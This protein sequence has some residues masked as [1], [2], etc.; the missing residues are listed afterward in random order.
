HLTGAAGGQPLRPRV[1]LDAGP[2]PTVRC[3]VAGAERVARHRVA[4]DLDGHRRFGEIVDVD[5]PPAAL[6]VPPGGV[7]PLDRR[8]GAAELAAAEVVD[9]PAGGRDGDGQLRVVE[10]VVDTQIGRQV[11]DGHIVG[12]PRHHGRPWISYRRPGR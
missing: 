8:V 10:A 2:R 6:V 11:T 12:S 7:E 5:R 3:G 9:R 1:E 4:G